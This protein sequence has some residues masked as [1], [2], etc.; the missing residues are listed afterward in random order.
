MM[1]S[2]FPATILAIM[3]RAIPSSPFENSHHQVTRK[4]G[5]L[6]SI[7]SVIVTVGGAAGHDNH[8]L[9]PVVFPSCIGASF[10][11][12]T[13]SIPGLGYILL[14]RRVIAFALTGTQTITRRINPVGRRNFPSLHVFFDSIWMT[15]S[16][17]GAASDRSDRYTGHYRPEY[18]HHF[19]SRM[20]STSRRVY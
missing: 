10:K 11:H 5:S 3:V 6:I 16:K 20:F 12:R 19:K 18:S 9:L 8:H 2:R 13:D 15:P 4:C 17:R 14:P 1:S 7:T